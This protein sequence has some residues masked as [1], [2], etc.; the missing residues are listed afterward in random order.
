MA[1][2]KHEL[3]ETKRAIVDRLKRADATVPQ[4]AA[5]LGITEAAVRQHLDAL[6]RN[7]L[8]ERQTLPPVGRGRP[9]SA[10]ALTDLA[11]DLF[12]DRHADLTVELLGALRTAL[13]DDGLARVID[14][15]TARQLAAYRRAVPARASLRAR[16]DALAAIRT[17][18]GYVGEVIE[19]DGL[20]L[21]EHHCPICAAATACQSLCS[22]EL[23]LFRD[24]LGP[25]VH[26][27]RTQH[28][29]SGDRHCAYR[30]TPLVRR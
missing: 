4:L 18:E 20:L 6:E 3:G 27:E 17:A 10:W 23:Q 14:E 19:D 24:V 11:R 28:L 7:G 29:L 25:K 9:V 8:V 2:V 21:V 1:P 26:V 13:G 30:I 15:R 22:S 5:A 12:P 16:V